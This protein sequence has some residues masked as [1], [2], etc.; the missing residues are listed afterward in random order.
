MVAS[1]NAWGNNAP[2]ICVTEAVKEYRETGDE[3]ALKNATNLFKA[4]KG[5]T[6]ATKDC[7]KACIDHQ[8][9]NA[10]FLLQL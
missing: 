6:D 2:M 1:K 9:G 10:S 3:T 7:L 5:S 8:N 4:L